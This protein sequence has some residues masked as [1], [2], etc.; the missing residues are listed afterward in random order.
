LEIYLK[1]ANIATFVFPEPVGAQINKFIYLLNA[2]SNV[3]DWI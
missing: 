1:I 2:E 3:C